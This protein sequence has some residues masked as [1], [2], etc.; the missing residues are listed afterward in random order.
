MTE[1]RRAAL[2]FGGNMGEVA[3]AFCYALGR[4][5]SAGQTKVLSR[6]S[7][8]RTAPW[9]RTDQPDFLNMAALIETSLPATDLLAL[10][11]TIEKERG[12]TRSE[13]WGPRTL[14]IDIIAYGD[15][16]SAEAALTLPH[17]RAPERAFVLIP[18][19]EIAPDLRLGAKTIREWA[20]SCGG[21]GVRL[22]EA[23]TK[24]LNASSIPSAAGLTLP[25]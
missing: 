8:Y 12:R 1:F 3:D 17:P 4:L 5:A 18:L 19:E 20:A 21:S 14:D 9:G 2:A 16:E 13:R 7:V 23:A 6:S 24:I 10:C 25:P 11:L 15:E 22:D